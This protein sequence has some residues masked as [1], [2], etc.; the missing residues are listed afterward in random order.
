MKLDNYLDLMIDEEI[1]GKNNCPVCIDGISEIIT[2]IYLEVKAQKPGELRKILK[3]IV[4]HRTFHSW[5]TG[6]DPVPIVKLKELIALWK[7]VCNKSIKESEALYDHAFL[8]ARNFRARKSPHRV[9]IIREIDE[10]L[11]YLIGVIYA[12]GALTDPWL[13]LRNK[14][15]FVYEI[16]ITE[17]LQN[18]LKPAVKHFESIFGVTTNVKSVYSGRWYRILFNSL[19]IHRLLHQLFE[20]PLGYKKGK[21]II[22]T[23]IKD[24]P[25]DIKKH[26]LVGFFD[27]DGWC[28]KTLN[29]TNFTPSVAASQSSRFILEDLQDILSEAGLNFNINTSTRDIYKWYTLVTKDRKQIQRY[30]DIFGFRYQNKKESLQKL[31]QSFKFKEAR[32]FD[33]SIYQASTYL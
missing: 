33:S 11:S 32:S 4:H 16:S 24:S 26:F 1:D 13:A 14:G 10:N 6:T 12:D 20:M 21:L 8:I 28:T 3:P 31:T 17:H 18:N 22:P 27:G 23:L 7:S 2:K 25:F 29:G 5:R 19:I 30:K 9:R 15:R